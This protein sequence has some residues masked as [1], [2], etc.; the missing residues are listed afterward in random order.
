MP[1]RFCGISHWSWGEP[2]SW[3][4]WPRWP[5][6]SSRSHPVPIT[7]QT[8]AVLVVGGAL[9]AIRGCTSL[10]LYLALGSAG[11]PIYAEGESGAFTTLPTGG[12]LVGFIIAAVVVGYL[13][14]KGWDRSLKS[15]LGAM[16]IGEIIVFGVGVPW[17]ANNLGV[18][19]GKAIEFG[20]YPFVIGDVIKLVLAAGL[21]PAAWRLV[22]K[23]P[24][25]RPSSA[26]RRPIPGTLP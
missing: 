9:G 22:G 1:I 3:P 23:S 19:A 14:E 21:L 13:S 5:S 20:L 11:A 12:F 8:L 2:H 7:G 26:A 6:P 25:G 16:L 10:I 24:D 15:S 18:S 17:L 4:S